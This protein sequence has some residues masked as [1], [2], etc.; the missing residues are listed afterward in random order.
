ML[1]DHGLLD[2]RDAYQC[3]NTRMDKEWVQLD[4]ML[5]MQTTPGYLESFGKEVSEG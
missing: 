5:K 4:N 1:P 2:M 3:E